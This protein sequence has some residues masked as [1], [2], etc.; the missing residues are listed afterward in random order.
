[1]RVR[2][3]ERSPE[4]CATGGVG[5]VSIHTSI[6]RGPVN[7]DALSGSGS[8]RRICR[9]YAPLPHY[10]RRA[11]CGNLCR[12]PESCH[13]RGA[14]G[15]LGARSIRRAGPGADRGQAEQ[16]EQTAQP[17]AS[18]RQGRPGAWRT[19]ARPGAP[20]RNSPL[21]Q[22][23]STP[24]VGMLKIGTAAQQGLTAP[25]RPEQ[26]LRASWPSPSTPS[27]SPTPVVAWVSCFR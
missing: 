8:S 25:R 11:D 12:A 22:I 4:T 3:I 21:S 16:R 23:R 15:Q 10:N 18:S 26:R 27:D 5:P 17:R 19:S 20:R 14:A 7:P 6:R 24:P 13:E 2:P 1:M 9:Q